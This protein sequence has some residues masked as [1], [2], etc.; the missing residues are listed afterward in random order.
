ME[1]RLLYEGPLQG[2][3]AKADHKREIRRHLHPQLKRLWTQ[4]PLNESSDLFA[5]PAQ[6]GKISVVELRGSIQF[7]PLV[8]RKLDL[9]AELNVLFL[10]PQPRGQLITDGGDIDNRLKTLIDALRIP[11][12]AQENPPSNESA[13][14]ENPLFCLLQDDSLVTKVTVEADQ[15]LDTTDQG[16]VKAI[17]QVVVKKSRISW[18]NMVF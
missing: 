1:F 13:S 12:T 7:I 18:A 14:D 6:A 17:I 9:Y 2:Q 8:T 16:H 3:N 10:R 4:P 11:R 15:L 5:F